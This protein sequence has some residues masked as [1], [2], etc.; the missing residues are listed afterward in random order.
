M[1]NILARGGIEFL[2]VLLGITISLWIDKNNQNSD[3]NNEIEKVHSVVELEVSKLISYTQSRIEVYAKQDRN[4]DFL[5]DNWSSLKVKNVELPED[6]STSI[7]STTGMRF[8]PNITT[9]DSF[10]SDGRF[11]L[12]DDEIRKLFGQFYSTLEAINRLQNKED[13]VKEKLLT[14]LAENH[15]ETIFK[16]PINFNVGTNQ[17]ITSKNFMLVI[18][19][20]R[21]DRAI[22]GFLARKSSL[23]KYRNAYV[24]D[25]KTDF[26]IIK[27]KLNQYLQ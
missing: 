7:W 3:L 16:Y 1:K 27:E 13:D 14:Y 17:S 25:I 4:I 24:L 11:N 5:F 23:A 18:E 10:K 12:I 15:S 9:F 26:E 6:F 20:T 2:A 22:Y 19:K 8:L 21:S